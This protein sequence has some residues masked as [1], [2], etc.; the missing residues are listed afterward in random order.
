[1]VC[2]LKGLRHAKSVVENKNLDED[3]VVFDRRDLSA[4][5]CL[6]ELRPA[7]VDLVLVRACH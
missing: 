5:V 4:D 3:R 1:M 7:T 6:Q 2:G